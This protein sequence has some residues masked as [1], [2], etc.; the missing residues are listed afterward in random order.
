MTASSNL[1]PAQDPLFVGGGDYHIKTGSPAIDQA[2]AAYAP[3]NDIDGDSRPQGSADDM[4]AVRSLVERLDDTSITRTFQLAVIPAAFQLI[5][6]IDAASDRSPIG[7]RAAEPAGVD[8]RHATS[9]GFQLDRLLGLSLCANKED[10]SS[11]GND[12]AD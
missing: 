10:I 6:L 9:P 1:D 4:G 11:L 12:V 7:K 8:V 5:Q 3:G 2:N